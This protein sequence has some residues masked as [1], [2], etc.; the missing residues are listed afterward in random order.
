MSDNR[1]RYEYGHLELT[2]GDVLVRYKIHDRF[3]T[4]KV[5][6]AGPKGLHL[7]RFQKRLQASPEKVQRL[8]EGDLVVV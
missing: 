4:L 5:R 8:L 1:F 6:M 2:D 3:V 7:E